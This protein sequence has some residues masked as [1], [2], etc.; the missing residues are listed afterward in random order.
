MA[1]RRAIRQGHAAGG[2]PRQRR[3]RRGAARQGC[4]QQA[5]LDRIMIDLDGTPNKGRLGANAIL[6][7]SMAAARAAAAAQRTPLYRYLGG[8]GASILPVPR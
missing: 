2:D 3:N 5:E 8:V 1:T 4:T 7:V 6:A